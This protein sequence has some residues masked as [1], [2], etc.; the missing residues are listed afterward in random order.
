MIIYEIQRD[1]ET[2]LT[3]FYKGHRNFVCTWSK[4]LGI[5]D[6]EFYDNIGSGLFE[7][8]FKMVVLEDE[9][10]EDVSG[11]TKE[12]EDLHAVGN[13]DVKRSD[14]TEENSTCHRALGTRIEP[15]KL[16]ELKRDWFYCDL[17]E[18]NGSCEPCKH[19]T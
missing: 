8:W 11:A 9:N 1:W 18:Y 4:I 6:Q 3:K 15:E 17:W 14:S 16:C 7:T 5:P 2:P 12:S 19:F 13:S 10:T